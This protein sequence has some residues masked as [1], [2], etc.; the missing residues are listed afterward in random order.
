MSLFNKMAGME[1]KIDMLI[2][3]TIGNWVLDDNGDRNG[4]K[5][6]EY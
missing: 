3:M 1:K 6:V 2:G 4:S 5:G